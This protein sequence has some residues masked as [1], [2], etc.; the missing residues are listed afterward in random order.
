M[1]AMPLLTRLVDGRPLPIADGTSETVSLR[2]IFFF[3]SESVWQNN[4]DELSIGAEGL[5]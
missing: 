2:R 5:F 4:C 3:L 1:M